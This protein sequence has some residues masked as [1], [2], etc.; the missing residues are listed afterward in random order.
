MALISAHAFKSSRFFAV[1]GLTLFVSACLGVDVDEVVQRQ[2]PGVSVLNTA[3]R[4]V[5]DGST[6]EIDSASLKCFIDRDNNDELLAAVTL[7]GR[8]DKKG[9]VPLFLAALNENDAVTSRTQYKVR[10]SGGDYEITLPNMAYGEKGADQK[11]RL[12]IGFV[13]TQAQLAAN[14]AFY[15]EKLG[16]GD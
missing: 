16:L 11:P 5:V 7:R 8:A 3:D 6:I 13:L 10:L 15:L 12:V 1:L 4:L 2:C 9:Q 14:R